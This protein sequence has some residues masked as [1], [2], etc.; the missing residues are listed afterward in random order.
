MNFPD[1]RAPTSEA[2]RERTRDLTR[3][4]LSV[5]NNSP[6]L[7]DELKKVRSNFTLPVFTRC[8]VFW[9]DPMTFGDKH[10]Q[11]EVSRLSNSI[12][13]QSKYEELDRQNQP[14]SNS[15]L[16]LITVVVNEHIS[17]IE[18]SFQITETVLY[19]LDSN[20]KLPI[21]SSL[22]GLEITDFD[23]ISNHSP[24]KYTCTYC[25]TAGKLIYRCSECKAA[26]YCNRVCQDA[27]WRFGH[28]YQC[29]SLGGFIARQ[30]APSDLTDAYC[31]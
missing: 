8:R 24:A 1:T 26:L 11:F 19:H 16:F 21:D 18:E 28:K 13:W 9:S 2:Q 6:T 5:I 4:V 30:F 22:P 10:L 25:G 14:P 3:I 31:N 7:L 23:I 20:S 27:H 17:E 29:K 15:P 12:A